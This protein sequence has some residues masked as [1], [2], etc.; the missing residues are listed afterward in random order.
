MP[1]VPDTEGFQLLID[2]AVAE[3]KA[4]VEVPVVPDT[5]GFAAR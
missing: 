3:A 2:D 1:V 4:S 5:A